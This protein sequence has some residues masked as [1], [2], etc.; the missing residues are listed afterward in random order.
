MIFVWLWLTKQ[1]YDMGWELMLS[2][3][4]HH[5]MFYK[6]SRHVLTKI[7]LI[8]NVLDLIVYL[9]LREIKSKKKG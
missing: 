5:I 6:D 1:N 3:C 8:S 7:N 9:I 2:L 4:Y